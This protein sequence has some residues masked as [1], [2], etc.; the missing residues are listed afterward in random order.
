MSGLTETEIRQKLLRSQ[1]VHGIPYP[2]L[3][4]GLPLDLTLAILRQNAS[5]FIANRSET[6]N[7]I[8][9]LIQ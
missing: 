1:S 8:F 5:Q 3:H 9:V 4:P 6:N 7:S 2:G